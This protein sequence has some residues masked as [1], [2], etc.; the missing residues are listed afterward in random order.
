MNT[1]R[2][3]LFAQAMA[4]P[5]LGWGELAALMRA[6]ATARSLAFS[7]LVTLVLA[8]AQH[9]PL[10]T[11]MFIYCGQNVIIGFFNV[12]RILGIRRMDTPRQPD[13][14]VPRAVTYFLAGFFTFHYGFFNFGY[15][16]FIGRPAVSEW[17]WIWLSLGAFFVHH[18]FSFRQHSRK[19]IDGVGIGRLMFFPYLRIV[20]MHLT[21]I[22]GG[23]FMLLFHNG[24]AEKAVLIFFLLLKTNADLNMH[25]V[26][27]AAE[28][29][30]QSGSAD[31]LPEK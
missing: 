1:N 17:G 12:I 5:F 11:I 10:K 30:P 25:K 26:E 15:F 20:P 18:L 27:H 29:R 31:P 4:R 3:V 14:E 23:F 21:I 28:D 19:K 2:Q 9:W 7:N 6:D 16:E 8:L 22:F 24:L 13:A